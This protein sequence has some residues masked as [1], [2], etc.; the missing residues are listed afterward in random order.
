MVPDPLVVHI[1]S[2]N[3]Y[4]PERFKETHIDRQQIQQ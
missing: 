4:V 1:L 3:E 2:K